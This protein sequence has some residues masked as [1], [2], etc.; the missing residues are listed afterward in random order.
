MLKEISNEDLRLQDIPSQKE[1]WW[2]IEQFALTF[3]DYELEK[4]AQ[5]AN[6]HHHDTL[7]NLRTCLFFEQ[8]RWRHFGDEP[9]EKSMIYIRDVLNMIRHKVAMGDKS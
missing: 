8:R 5:I 9:D 2:A 1:D 7:T 3:N 6:D 4:C